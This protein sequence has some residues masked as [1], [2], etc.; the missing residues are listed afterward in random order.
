[1]KRYGIF[2]HASQMTRISKGTTDTDLRYA[3]NFFFIFQI[4][5]AYNIILVLGVHHSD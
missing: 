1:M 3:L 4:Q 2:N 5:F